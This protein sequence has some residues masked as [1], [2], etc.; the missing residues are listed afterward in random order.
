MCYLHR[1][2]RIGTLIEVI[3]TLLELQSFL[4][5]NIFFYRIKCKKTLKIINHILVSVKSKLLSINF[6]PICA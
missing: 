3:K 2:I 5:L 6:I 4:N 1:L